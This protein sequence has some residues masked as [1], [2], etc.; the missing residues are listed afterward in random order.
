MWN[1]SFVLADRIKGTLLVWVGLLVVAATVADVMGYANEAALP[2]T[3]F[4]VVAQAFIVVAA[5]KVGGDRTTARPNFVRVLGIV[6]LSG[7]GIVLGVFLLVLPGIFLLVRWWVAVPVALDRDI[8]VVEALRESWTMTAD[9]WRPIAGLFLG[10]L[11]LCAIPAAVLFMTGDIDEDVMAVGPSLL[12]NLVIYGAT[13][14][15]TVSTVAVYRA[16]SGQGE[17][18]RVVFE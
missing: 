11:A 14:F 7:I 8:G 5:L 18:L 3:I 6:L 2:L 9:H 10:L 12:L 17:D 15:G 1:D 4:G 13:N 16:I